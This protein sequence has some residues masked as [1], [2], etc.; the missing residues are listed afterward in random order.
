M[1]KTA[2]EWIAS[3]GEI[4]DD[5]RDCFNGD[6]DWDTD[7]A[8]GCYTCAVDVIR[9][10]Q[11]EALKEA[12]EEAAVVVENFLLVDKYKWSGNIPSIIRALNGQL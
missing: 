9:Q 4:T 6:H 5:G 2:E 10:I 12:L 11:Q 3:V 1:I 8:L 7:S